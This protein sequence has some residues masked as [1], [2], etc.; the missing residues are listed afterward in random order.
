[1]TKHIIIKVHSVATGLNKRKPQIFNLD[2]IL[3]ILTE[4]YTYRNVFY[5]IDTI[6]VCVCVCVCV[7]ACACACACACVYL[8]DVEGLE[9]RRDD[10]GVPFQKKLF[11]ASVSPHHLTMCLRQRARSRH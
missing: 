1:M 8:K 5:V 3:Y 7:C 9:R 2:Y 10:S 4:L 6:C 11:L